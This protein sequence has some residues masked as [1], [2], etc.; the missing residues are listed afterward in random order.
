MFRFAINKCKLDYS[1]LSSTLLKLGGNGTS[2][3][4]VLVSYQAEPSLH[5][6]Y[7]QIHVLL[8]TWHVGLHY[9]KK[10]YL[11]F[12]CVFFL[13][14]QI[15]NQGVKLLW[16][17]YWKS[18]PWY[19]KNINCL[20]HKLGFLASIVLYLQMVVVQEKAARAL[21]VVAWDRYACQQ[22]TLP[23]ILLMQICGDSR[24]LV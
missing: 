11:P 7:V 16:Q 6:S 21:M 17:K 1:L 22:L 9:T 4:G 23:L 19:V 3:C 8:R 15:C 24:K 18:L 10:L 13:L 12:L 20:R 2:A 14:K 5:L